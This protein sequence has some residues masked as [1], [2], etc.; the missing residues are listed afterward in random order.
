MVDS[1]EGVPVADWEDIGKAL[2]DIT[3]KKNEFVV[4]AKGS[5]GDE[6]IQAALWNPGM[7]LRP[8]Y[9][10]EIST[11]GRF[12]RT[13]TKD[14]NNIYSAFRAYYDGWDPIVKS[15]DDV[16]DELSDR[17]PEHVVMP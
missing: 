6:F 9:I 5:E 17:V 8:S 11:R 3:S 2:A 15:W 4:L 12:Y 16:T 1:D 10:M 14:F 7:V 13:K